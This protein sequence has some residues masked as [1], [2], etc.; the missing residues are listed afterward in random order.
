[1]AKENS[2][3]ITLDLFHA[4]KRA[5]RPR[6][7]PLPRQEQLRVNKHNQLVRD[8]Q[9][10]LKRVELKVERDL[11]D[12]LNREAET[13]KISRSALIELLLREQLQL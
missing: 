4:E 10:G 11:F 1:M 9:R 5:G 6:T 12:A 3:R 2:D 8:R 7:N 13:R